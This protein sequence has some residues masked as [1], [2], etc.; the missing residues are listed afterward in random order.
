MNES[1]VQQKGKAILFIIKD[2]KGSSK[3]LIFHL[4]SYI[5]TWGNDITLKSCY[6]TAYEMLLSY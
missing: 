6:Q 2:T 3:G 1:T 5:L 4:S